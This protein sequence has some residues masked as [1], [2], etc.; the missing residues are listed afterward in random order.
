MVAS[1]GFLDE[2]PDAKFMTDELETLHELK[3]TVD[4]AI[5]CIDIQPMF[6]IRDEICDY[7]KEDFDFVIGNFGVKRIR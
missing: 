1:E 7:T 2:S 6:P 3:R 4:T 5:G